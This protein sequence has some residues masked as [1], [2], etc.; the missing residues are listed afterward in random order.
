MDSKRL[1]RDFAKG[2]C[3]WKNCKFVHASNGQ[4]QSHSPTIPASPASQ[5]QRPEPLPQRS[6]ILP[7]ADKE[8]RAWQNSIPL[9]S[10]V[11]RPSSGKKTTLFQKARELIGS[12]ASIRQEVIRTLAS[13]DGLRLILDLVQE[14]FEEM[15]AA[16]RDL[17]FKTQVL[18]FLETIT[19]PEVASSLVLEQAVGT[20][21]NVL[22]GLDGSRAARWL[23]FICGVLEIDTTNE[24]SAMLLEASLHT[25]SRIADLNSTAPVQDCL[26]AVAQRF[27]TV[28]TAMNDKNGMSGRLYQSRMHLDR[29]LQRMETGNSLSTGT[30]ENKVKN[31]SN[32]AFVAN[33]ETPG[34][35][36]NNDFDDI[37]QIKIMPTF[38][39]ICSLRGEYLPVNNPLQWHIDG[40]D[41]LLDRNFRLLR[42][43]TVGQLR[44]AIH[45]ELSPR[46]QR[47]QLRRFVY[48]NSI[49]VKLEFNWLWGFYFEVDFPQPAGVRNFTPKARETWWQNSKRLQP[50]ALVCLIVQKDVVVFCTVTHRD[51]SPR[52]RKDTPSQD[53]VP[54]ENKANPRTLW[55]SATRGSVMLMPVDSRCNNT[56]V[57]L[58]LFDSKKANM[59][60]VEFP[61]VILPA[62]EPALRALQSMKRTKNLPFS[63]LFV[64]WTFDDFNLFDMAPP[65]YALQPGFAFNLRCLMKND[66]NFYVRVDQ[67]SNV[68]YVQ[69]NSTL[70]GAQAHAL[71]SCL[72]RKLGLIQGPPGTGK[73]YTGVALIKVL[74]AN[75]DAAA[76]GNLGP[77]LCVTYT[78]HALDQLLESLLDNKVTSQIVRIGSQSKSERLERFNLHIVARDTPR[79]KMEK[80][81]RWSTAEILSYCEEDFRALDLKNEVSIARLKSYIQRTNPSQHNQ[82]FSL[83]QEDGSLRV[84]KDNP[85]TAINSWVDSAPA[86]SARARPVE[87][88]KNINV[89]E[90]SREERQLLY[91][92]WCHDYRAEVEERVRR[93][94]S[95]H[96]IAKKGYDSVQDEMH[97]RCLAEA[98]VI[99]ITTAGLARRLDMFRR[100]QCKFMLCEEAGEVLESHILT[101][102][103]P[104]VEHAVLIGDQQQ[105]RPQ[106]QN[107]D[108]SSENHR[109]GAQYSLD[110]SLFERLVSSNKSPM[111]CGA[112]FSTLETQR[113]M[114]PSIARLVRKTLYPSLKDAPSVSEYPEIMGMRK[115]LFWLDHRHQEGGSDG[116]SMSTSHWNSHEIDMT[117]AL[118]NH[119]VQQ[120][121]YKHGDIA[122]LTPYL[123]QLHRLRKRFD[124]LFAIMV[125]NRDRVELKQAGFAG[126]ETKD[127]PTIKAAL[128]E[129]L[130]MATVD[131]FQGEEAKVVVISLVRSNA[132]N[133]CGFL[134]TSNRINVL[135]S[136]AQHGMYIIG[137]SQTSIHVP[138]W[139]Q[140]V[141][142]LRQEHNIGKALELQ[143]PRHPDTPI[144]VSTPEDFPKFSPEGGCNLRCV[145]RLRCGHACIQKCHSDVL[146][147]AVFCL[148]P[149][150][151]SLGGCNHPCPKRCGD[152]CPEKCMVNVY[153]KDRTLLCGHPMPDLPCWQDQDISKHKTIAASLNAAASFLVDTYARRFVT[154][155]SPK[156]LRA[157]QLIMEIA[158]NGVIEIN[159]HALIPA[160]FLATLRSPVLH[161]KLLARCTAAI[162]SAHEN[163]MSHVLPARKKNVFQRVLTASVQCRVQP[164]V[165][166]FHV[167]SDARR[168][169]NVGT[170]ALDFIL[171]ETYREINLDENPCVFPK[172]GHFLTIENMDA[173]MDM[174]SYYDVDASGKPVSICVSL[175]PFSIQDIKTCATCRGPLRDISRYGRLVRRAILDESTKKLIIFLN[176]EYVPLAQELPQLVRELHECDGQRMYP[177]PAVIEISGARSHQIQSMGEIIESTNPGRWDAIL[178]L[179]KRVDLY[180][181]H[182]KPEEQPF[183]RVRRMIENARQRQ[184]LTTNPKHVDNVLQTK[185]FLQGTALLIRLDIALIVDLLDL[186]SQGRPHL[187][188]PRF[189]LDLQ[190]MKDDC[191]TLIRHAASHHR[192]LQQAEGHIFLAQLYA[193]ERAHCLT[194]EKRNNILMHG[195]ASIQKAKGL[196]DAHPG[197]TRGLADEVHSVE[198]ML[199]GG[200]FYTIITNEERMSVLSA[201]AQEFR[202]TG[203]WYYCRNGHPFTIG[204]CGL[205]REIS[206][207]P[208]CDAPVGG[209][210]SE[211]ADGVRLAVDWDLDRERL[212]L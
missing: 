87:E 140:V 125:G 197:Q 145:N 97:L 37:C 164:L 196:C 70:D 25:F 150:P 136:R 50:G 89:F 55:K 9:R 199:R 189:E 179:R 67:P 132:K 74:L 137:N 119:L 156:D 104:S 47:S 157:S 56:Q 152:R 207:C 158:N 206:R 141:K 63:E 59:S 27:E 162:P 84:Q 18:P 135:L 182:V 146:H 107:Y 61:G 2:N 30:T 86:G 22:F 29:L 8:F 76:G 184:G 118:V 94:V 121:E 210:S 138:M 122:V 165:T 12:D 203:H 108:L 38:E 79:T 169:S 33:R 177:W 66:T 75:K 198:K 204:D 19:N 144:V 190:K 134:R 172:C 88:L 99:G 3:R 193:L 148:E 80:K 175:A 178:D 26:H 185:G 46:A 39:E 77:I 71:I 95:S 209:E 201:M 28:L 100:L 155:A 159:L 123:G 127:K 41:G 181:R 176:Q 42:E 109:G 212:N 69:D 113:R 1:C 103:L 188:A 43:D 49:V 15:N 83:V 11:T 195:Q 20:I 60:L 174:A 167:P 171:G 102:F 48:P 7:N 131:N 10:T 24:G 124:E 81:E 154:A 78:N 92:R 153:Q 160:T 115:R 168:S 36:H 101:A 6:C 126:Y 191:Q 91:N 68:K 31:E 52:Y 166:M 23:N 173:Q 73:S 187:V 192:L 114:H 116:D 4:S 151:R 93:I 54:P 57:V 110:I 183:E 85:Q 40:V 51:M 120:G 142:I 143:C 21:Y 58:D 105:L 65:L 5:V 139:A 202:G 14:N 200:T 72:K 64:P 62:F 133:Q 90:M 170:S 34:G 96:E 149:C 17:L 208:E 32:V 163:A 128:S 111:D 205:A 211:L 194:P 117:V 161:A 53:H 129:T 112:P 98:D 82:L 35:R 45:H 147:N 13:E 44:D 186:G 130:R 106:V 16:T 180:R